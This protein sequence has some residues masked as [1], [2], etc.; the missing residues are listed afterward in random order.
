MRDRIGDRAAWIFSRAFY[1]S[2]ADGVSVQ[3]AVE[4]GKTALALW[5]MSEEDL[6]GLLCRQGVDPSRLGLAVGQASKPTRAQPKPRPG[7]KRVQE[8][9]GPPPEAR[10]AA[11][12]TRAPT[13]ATPPGT[14]TN[15]IGMALVPIP[16]GEFLMGSPDSDP[17]AY[18]WEKPQHRVRI[19]RP[20]YLGACPV[21]QAEYRAVMGESPSHFKEQPENP[22]EIVSWYDA[23]RFCNRLS[24]RDDLRP[25]YSIA[26][27][28]ITVPD[29][30]GAGYRLPTE[31][32]WEYAC[33]AG[34]TTRYWFG[35]DPAAL[36]D[37][38]WYSENSAG[39]THPVREKRPNSW[40][41]YDMHG[42]V[43]EWCWDLWDAEYYRQFAS[44][45][46]VDDP[47]GPPD[48]LA[49]EARPE[50]RSRK[51]KDAAEPADLQAPARV[52]R[53]G[54]WYY[55]PRHLRSA[56]R[57]RPRPGYRSYYL[58]FRVARVQSNR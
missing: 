13:S 49:S 5:G 4:H 14:I 8:V 48:V 51:S 21:T 11:P 10:P 27:E 19:T 35:D 30:D 25:F 17:D 46:L 24:E 6:P 16:A 50:K 18:D 1:E 3:D 52:F 26:G 58:G 56:S 22:V 57:I 41:L 53:G 12:P 23:V 15:S 33:R 37:Y 39:R 31:A 54:S 7:K 36:G 45:S 29:W 43:W 44:G 32:E 9:A 55:A 42:H 38:A 2:L 28:R 47:R 40:G 34:T 20:F